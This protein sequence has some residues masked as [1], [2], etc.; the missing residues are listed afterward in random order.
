M[1]SNRS[2]YWYAALIKTPTFYKYIT[3]IQIDVVH[4]R[5]ADIESISRRELMAED[6]RR[7]TRLLAATTPLHPY[8]PYLSA[9]TNNSRQTSTISCKD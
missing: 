4:R 7:I 2:G 6:P 9:K 5:M 3:Y 1:Y 8:W